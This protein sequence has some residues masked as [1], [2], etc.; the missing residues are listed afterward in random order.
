MCGIAG[1][2]SPVPLGE[3]QIEIVEEM[4]LLNMKLLK[5]DASR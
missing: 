5:E 4:T 3:E 2:I 1:V